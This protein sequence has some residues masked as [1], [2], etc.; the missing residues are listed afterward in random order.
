M[1]KTD[2]VY[3]YS[4]SITLSLSATPSFLSKE[5]QSKTEKIFGKG[6]EILHGG[7]KS[8]RLEEVGVKFVFTIR[9]NV[10]LS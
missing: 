1:S 7:Q 2:P 5:L 8:I 4:C 6:D 3:Q 10:D 9:S